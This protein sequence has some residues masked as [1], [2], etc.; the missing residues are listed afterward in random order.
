M[1]QAEH[2]AVVDVDVDLY[3]L[4]TCGQWPQMKVLRAG[5]RQVGGVHQ[6]M[7]LLC[8]CIAISMYSK[9]IDAINIQNRGTG[10]NII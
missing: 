1:Q 2:T 5:Y 9:L 3:T 8:T 6:N 7:R 10:V 4:Y